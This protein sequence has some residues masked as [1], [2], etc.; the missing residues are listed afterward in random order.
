V[1]NLTHLP[2][3]KGPHW[4]KKGQKRIEGEKKTPREE[5]RVA[6]QTEIKR[7]QKHNKRGFYKDIDDVGSKMNCNRQESNVGRASRQIMARKQP[8]DKPL[9]TWPVLEKREGS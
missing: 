2:F 1:D 6:K 4:E 8:G 7:A 5:R 3:R 9:A